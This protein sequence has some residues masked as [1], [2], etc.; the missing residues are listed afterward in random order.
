VAL[1]AAVRDQILAIDKNQPLD[2]TKTMEQRLSAS[3]AGR[4]MN[5]LLLGSFAL[6]AIILASVR[7]YGVMSYS[8]AQRTHEIGVRMA[9]GAEQRDVLVM[10]I[11]RGL[12]LTL[13]GVGIGLVGAL[14]MTRFMASILYG[15]R[16]TDAI[17]FVGV[18]LLLTGVAVVA[19][20]IP[21]RRATRV[22][23]MVA[24]RYE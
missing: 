3:V 24:L 17:T 15:V 6:L 2:N 12:L 7:I 13:A 5:M 1:V 19:C 18:S 10:V 21:A 20:Y 4:R 14:A 23:P 8:V 9:L 22:D 11:S 16:P